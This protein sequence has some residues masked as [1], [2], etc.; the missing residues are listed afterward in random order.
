MTHTVRRNIG[1]QSDKRCHFR[2][3]VIFAFRFSSTFSRSNRVK[4]PRKFGSFSFRLDYHVLGNL[5]SRRLIRIWLYT[6]NRGSSTGILS[7]LYLIRMMLGNHVHIEFLY[8]SVQVDLTLAP[9]ERTGTQSCF[10][11]IAQQ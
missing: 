7:S 1:A 11:V 2:F 10:G 8:C 5:F 4:C 9:F 6:F 3:S